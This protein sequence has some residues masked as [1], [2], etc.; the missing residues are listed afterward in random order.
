MAMERPTYLALIGDL[1]SSRKIPEAVRY[2]L[3]G[4]LAAHLGSLTRERTKGVVARPLITIGDE[5]QALFSADGDG[6][7]AATAM[8]E[9]TLEIARP[10]H[11]RF[12]LGAGALDT[13][14]RE[15][16]LGM[17]GPCFHRART[18][19][20]CA[21]SEGVL[22]V[23][24]LGGGRRQATWSALASYALQQRVDWTG[25]QHDAVV[26]YEKLGAWSRV[27]DALGISRGAVSLR[28]RNA[29][30]GLYTTAREALVADL[31]DALQSTWV[32]DSREV[33]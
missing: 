22:C 5:F 33:P 26:M 17:D 29:H 32:D 30:W 19:I 27:A 20:E 23:L 13:A 7:R 10:A 25:P 15:E 16:A 2:D 14:L 9:S 18:A 12:G 4:R 8:L 3:Q 28:Q 6:A 21:R 24:D 11:V 31:A 1:V